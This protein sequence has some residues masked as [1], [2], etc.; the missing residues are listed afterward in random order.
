MQ[1]GDFDTH[2]DA[3]GGIQVRE[4][5]IEQEHARLGHQR[6]ADRHT[7]TLT[8]GERLRFTLQQ[9]CQLEHFRHLGD[10]LVNG[11]FFRA[12]QLQAKG[13]VLGNGKMR[14]KRIRLEHHAHAAF[15]WRD[16]V[17]SGITNK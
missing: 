8:T 4:R 9:M 17:H 14:I 7:L 13:H 2:L 3:Q 12:G 6:T 1:T 16:V 15:S 5:F 11:L 10:A